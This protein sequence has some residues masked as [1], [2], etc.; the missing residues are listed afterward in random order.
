MIKNHIW[1]ILLALLVGGLYAA[2]NIYHATT[3]GYRGIIMADATDEDFYLSVINKSY[4]SAGPVG[5]PF[6][7]EYRNAHNPFQYFALEYALGKAG[8]ALRLPIDVLTIL[9]EFLFP[10]LLALLLYAFAL[11]LSRSHLTGLVASAMMLL[12]NEIVQPT[13]LSNLLHTFLLNGSYGTFLTY[14]RPINPQVSSIF[15]FAAL[16]GLLY[17]SRNPRSKWAMALSGAGVG[18]LVYIYPYFW[19]FAF[20]LLGVMFFYALAVRN[21]PLMLGAGVAGMVSVLCMA[22][23]LFLNASIFLQGGGSALMQAIPTHRIIIEK[24]ILAPLFL[25]AFLY[26]WA[27][28]SEGVGKFGAWT[29]A[30]AKKY[31]FILLLLITG[32]IVSN[33]QVLTGKLMFPQHFHFYTNIPLFLLSMSLLMMEL[34]TLFPRIW[35]IGAASAL[36]GVVAWFSLGVQVS[37][38]KAHRIESSRYQALAPIFAYL[39]DIAP[40]QSVVLADEYLST[41]LTIYTQDFAYAT[42]GYDTTFA[43]PQERI[44]HDHFVRLAL[45]GVTVQ[46]VRDYVYHHRDEVSGALYIATYWRDLCGSYGCFPDSILEQLIS[47]YQ[48]FSKH[49]LLENIK[50]YKIEYVLVDRV[51]DK[52]WN[53]NKIVGAPVYQSGDFIL[54]A[55]R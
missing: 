22:P 38:Y 44:L 42:G 45:R 18:L 23:F 49:S 8:A 54:Y 24:M 6:Q 50:K 5:D 26:A 29:S 51:Q 47:R 30:F 28:W 34:L 10:A 1:A 48:S 20:V 7:Y 46:S 14:S 3:P 9:M 13:A 53:I 15:F 36:I 2:P 19:A 16:F 11:V 12:G 31:T 17:L 33:Q 39:R 40:P 52:E 25:Y 32:V 4:A 35:R 21:R 27:W 55:I 43:V 37:S 41:R